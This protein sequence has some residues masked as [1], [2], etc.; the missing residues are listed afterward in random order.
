MGHFFAYISRMKFINRWA[1]M[2]NT[3]AESL[4]AHSFDVAVIANALCVIGNKRL[5][6]SYNAERAAVIAL[7]H[8]ASEIITGD[9]PTPVK[10][11]NDEIKKAYKSVEK[12]A[13]E[14]LLTYLPE[15]LKDY[16]GDILNPDGELRILVKAADKISAC[17]KCAEEM[18]M[19]NLEFKSALSAC[20]DTVKAMNC[21]EANIFVEEFLGS[22]SLSL[23][24]LK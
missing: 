7:Y 2:R 9:M 18:K 1:L 4:S 15:D 20:L 19:G 23:D 6:K 13:N 16:Y 3:N 8:D 17:I 11:Y 22:Y 12:V 21:P 14:R 24:E 10:Y 5:G